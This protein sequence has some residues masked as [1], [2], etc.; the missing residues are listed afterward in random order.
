MQFS[1]VHPIVL[2]QF[3]KYTFFHLYITECR[4]HNTDIGYLMEVANNNVMLSFIVLLN[5]RAMIL[6]HL[7]LVI[8]YTSVNYL[9]RV[10]DTVEIEG[11]C[12]H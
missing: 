1:G 8:R 7:S 10:H 5:F 9:V 3:Y 11:V 6:W 12:I 4:Q 2:S